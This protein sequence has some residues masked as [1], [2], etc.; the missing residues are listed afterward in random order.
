MAAL[1][2][3]NICETFS[4]ESLSPAQ[5]LHVQ[6]EAMRLAF[7]DVNYYV[8]DPEHSV[9]T[10]GLLDKE[11]ARQRATLIRMD[12]ASLPEKGRPRLSCDTVYF[13]AVDRF[14]NACSFINSNYNG[15]GTGIVPEGYG[16][17]LQNRGENFY[18]GNDKSHPNLVGPNKRSYHTIIPAMVTHNDS[19][20]LF[21]AAGVMGGFMQPQGHLQVLMSMFE[22]RLSP[23]ESLDRC[24]FCIDPFGDALNVEAGVDAEIVEHLKKLGH[25][26]NVVDSWGRKV[27]CWIDFWLY[28]HSLQLFGRGQVIQVDD[29]G[30]RRAGCDPRSDGISMGY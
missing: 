11:Y 3:L 6:V 24:R 23:Q 10:A 27:I 22:D 1:I 4:W 19:G 29:N 8:A 14:G 28:S 20:R 5:R 9:A 2:A 15:F 18:F 17:S 12:S 26:V 16:F 13:C 7:A 30:V 21:A 25:K